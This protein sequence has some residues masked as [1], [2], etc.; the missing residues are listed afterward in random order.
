VTSN[1]RILRILCV[2][3]L[4]MAVGCSASPPPPP[5]SQNGEPGSQADALPVTAKDLPK[6]AKLGKAKA[7]IE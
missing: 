3:A 1:C 5:L 7:F 6:G 2:A 4:T